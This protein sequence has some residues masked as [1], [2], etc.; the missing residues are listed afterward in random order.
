MT[1]D[2]IERYIY[3]VTKRMSEKNRKDVS[4]E[5]RTLIDDML[6]E[7]C[8]DVVPDEKDI[9][10]V[11]TELGTPQ[12]L[13]EK[14]NTDTK[15]CL[16][17][18]PYYSTYKYVLKIVLICITIGTVISTFVLDFLTTPE[19]ATKITSVQPWIDMFV[20][21]FT[22]LISESI[23][24]FAF[25]TLLFAFF[26]HKNINIDTTSNLDDLPPIPKESKL[27]SKWDSIIGIGLSVI[28][29]VVFLAAPQ[30]FCVILTG[31]SE[32][33]PIFNI[34]TVRATWYIIALF[35]IAGIIREVIKLL[36]GRY[37][38]KVMVSTIVANI[39]SAV[40]S[41]WWFTNDKL[42]NPEFNN[43]LTEFFDDG[44]V[45]NIFSNFPYFFFGCILLALTIDCLTTVIKTIKK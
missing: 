33:I 34:E 9:K 30:I 21:L 18:P 4:D 40:L 15:K 42:I 32:I 41:F 16:I 22:M 39:V 10:V 5:L 13:S 44:I 14:Y 28:F 17:G 19:I 6:L 8:G 3:A 38:K 26:Y 31:T 7:R 23:E 20:S 43:R 2:L 29:L 45:L 37:S 35:S 12:E 36:E 24:A 11:L 27:I 25:V 1:N